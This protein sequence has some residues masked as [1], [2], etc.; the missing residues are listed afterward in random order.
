MPTRL[1]YVARLR[2]LDSCFL[3]TFSISPGCAMWMWMQLQAAVGLVWKP[4]GSK[5]AKGYTFRGPFLYK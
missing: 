4:P 2:L 1:K 3:D 5:L